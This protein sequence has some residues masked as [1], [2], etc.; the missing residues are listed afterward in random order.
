[1]EKNVQ[2]NVAQDIA[3]IFRANRTLKILLST[4]LV[5]LAVATAIG[6]TMLA[7]MTAGKT[8]IARL[9]G[10]VAA[11]SERL[12]R[13][14][15]G[16]VQLGTAPPVPDRAATRSSPTAPVALSLTF[17]EMSVVRTVIRLPPPPAGA[18]PSIAI[19]DAV[20]EPRL[21][22][23]PEAI[24]DKLPKLRGTRFTTDRNQAIVIVGR[25]NRAEAIIGPN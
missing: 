22:P 7:Q 16:T 6:G 25:G 5:M 8:E 3:W 13:I 1:M 23:M 17:D 14:E 12:S 9:R 15:K 21:M 2:P 24:V 18:T 11:L 19:G 20:P 10:D 4:I